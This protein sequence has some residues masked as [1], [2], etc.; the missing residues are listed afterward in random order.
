VQVASRRLARRGSSQTVFHDGIYGVRPGDTGH[1]DMKHNFP[2]HT[3][4]PRQ[5]VFWVT[6]GSNSSGQRNV[7]TGSRA[8]SCRHSRG[9]RAFPR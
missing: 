9:D 4:N 2:G 6:L 5:Y 1:T 3:G 7:I 8:R